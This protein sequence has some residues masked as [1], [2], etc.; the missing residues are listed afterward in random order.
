MTSEKYILALD[1][2]TT[3]SRTII[4][5]Q[6][7]RVIGK[8]QK[9]F[10]QLFPKKGWVEHDANEIY[11]TQIHVLKSVL[12]SHEIG[13]QQIAGIGITNQRET[14][15]V[16]D[17]NT[18]IPVYNAI[19]WQDKRTADYCASLKKQGYE[20]M[21]RKKT[22]L[23]I[24]SYFSAT[25]IRWILNNVPPARALAEKGALLFGTI[26]TWLIWKLT[27]GKVHATD[28]SNASRTLLYNIN[29]L[30]WD[31][32]LLNLFDIPIQMMPEVKASDATF[33][34]TDAQIVG[35]S[36]SINAVLGDQQAALF[37]QQC[38]EEGKAK[39][40]Y[41]TGCFLLL[42]T[43]TKPTFS[44]KGLI[45][46]IAWQSGQKTIYALEGSVFIGGAAIQWLRDGLQI[47]K[48]ASETQELAQ[49]EGGGS[50]GIYFVPT[51]AGM[52][53]PYWN[54]DA[55]GAI[56]GITRDTTKAHIVSA[57][58]EGIAYQS[59]DVLKAMEADCNLS[60]KS[61]KVDGG[62]TAN[63]YLMQFQA[64]ILN[65]PVEV[66]YIM[67]STALGVAIMASISLGL[68]TRAELSLS[69]NKGEK[70]LPKMTQERIDKCYDG[71]KEA[72]K[73]IS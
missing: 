43:G 46:T 41:G 4:F 1:Q 60:L 68:T 2:G 9:E 33:G 25:K 5:S 40:T 31:K 24:D 19:V 21:I 3:S 6:K 15:V 70:Y 45:T 56:M 57:T 17:K 53:A 67:E 44:T 71:W 26:D 49:G 47:I 34:K 27:G 39:N 65:T 20:D 69:T 52:G 51:F 7:G 35:A 48:D 32:E 10:T 42:N 14:T 30:E 64:D 18:G 13:V 8:S 73:R 54:M 62:A 22:G 23:P 55:R 61:L 38:W 37:G 58:L 28:P 11:D 72:I 66:A 63:A 16:W 36:I 50:N 29:D 12:K 59:M